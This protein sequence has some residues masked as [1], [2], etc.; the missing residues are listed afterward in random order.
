M[1][2]K[3]VQAYS[4][5]L[6]L[7]V[8]VVAVVAALLGA[9]I[10][11]GSANAEW[12]Y[13]LYVHGVGNVGNAGTSGWSASSSDHYATGY[14]TASQ[15]LYQ[16]RAYIR[17]WHH[18]PPGMGGNQIQSY[19]DT[20]YRYWTNAAL[21]NQIYASGYGDIATTRSY[22]RYAQW[23]SENTYHTSYP[24]NA[25]SCYNHWASGNYC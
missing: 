3:A 4:R 19:H 18:R 20:G 2:S 25:G 16:I 8:M 21:T 15:T 22:F 1:I 5:H 24:D 23:S 14:S 10:G 7:R 17:F 9:V 12:S 13:N 11:V 6:V